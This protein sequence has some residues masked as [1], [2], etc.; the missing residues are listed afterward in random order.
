MRRDGFTLAEILVVLV[1]I[2]IVSAAVAPALVRGSRPRPAAAAAA[3]VRDLLADTRRAAVRRGVPVAIEFDTRAG[4][5]H[6]ETDPGDERVAVTIAKG[7]LSLPNGVV[8]DPP[9]SR[10]RFVFDA[11]GTGWGPKVVLRGEGQVATVE[12]DRWTGVVD[13]SR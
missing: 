7:T 3:Q 11:L 1:V 2:G 9:A 12:I 5:Y 4:T 10:R 8:Y 6:V 13:A